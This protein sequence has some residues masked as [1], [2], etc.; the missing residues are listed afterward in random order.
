MTP[1]EIQRTQDYYNWYDDQK[2]YDNMIQIRKKFIRDRERCYLCRIG[3][4]LRS[5]F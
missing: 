4:W 3:L 2:D 5:W 1:A